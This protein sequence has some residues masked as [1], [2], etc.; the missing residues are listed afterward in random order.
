MVTSIESLENVAKSRGVPGVVRGADS[1]R[2][3]EE[4][5]VK[6]ID[7]AARVTHPELGARAFEKVYEHNPLLA[8]AITVIKAGLDLT[9]TIIGSPDAM[10]AAVN[11]TE[12]SEA[13]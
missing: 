2:I 13:Y 9:P 4:E 6:L 7:T 3:T 8:R 12:S 11:N 5:F 1:F 10:H